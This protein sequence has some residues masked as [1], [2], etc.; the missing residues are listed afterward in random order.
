[1]KVIKCDVCSTVIEEEGTFYLATCNSA[2]LVEGEICSKLPI[3]I[4]DS[5]HFCGLQ[6]VIDS[7]TT[8]KKEIL[9]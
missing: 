8:Y 1:M 9:A 7:L 5:N 2:E 6:C 3:I 4:P